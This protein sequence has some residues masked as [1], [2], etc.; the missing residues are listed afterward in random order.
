[1]KV[2]YIH[3]YYTEKG[4]EDVVFETEK[5]KMQLNGITVA[6]V[7]FNNARYS[8]FKIILQPFNLLSYYRI[9]RKIKLFKPD[10]IHIHNL[11]FAASPAVV[12]AAVFCK[13][14]V[15]MTLHNYRLICPSAILY[16]NGELFLDSLKGGFP[17]KA[18]IKK[19]YKD[20]FLLSFWLACSIRLHKAL[21]TWKKVEKFI[22]LTEF[23]KKI[24]LQSDIGILE[25]QMIVKANFVNNHES[26]AAIK[27]NNFIYVGRLSEEKGI[28]TIIQA[29]E[30]FSF[31]L[32]IIGSGPLQKE[33]DDF[34]ARN[35]CVKYLGFQDR[36]VVQEALKSSSALLFPSKSFEGM[37]MTI[38]EALAN[39]TPVIASS[40]GSIPSIIQDQY[41]GM[42]FSPGNSH[43]LVTKIKLWITM[44]EED[45]NHYYKNAY[46][47]YQKK[48]SSE[49]SADKMLKIYQKVIL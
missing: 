48:Y 42:L 12:W 22:L 26:N 34:T 20:S 10:L 29:F 49:I 37:P 38:L 25:K 18:V 45:K 43:D 3:T 36:L 32:I 23:S 40:L 17:W 14:P 1:M 24:F 8:L 33:V 46:N 11:H 39:G 7:L 6:S 13:V 4:G 28:D 5:V 31:N 41:N 47:T 9:I 35:N 15:V 30:K 16:H 27:K 19:V 2:L 21:G 44:D